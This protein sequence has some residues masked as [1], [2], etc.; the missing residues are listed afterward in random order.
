MRGRAGE[1]E[2]KTEREGERAREREGESQTH[3]DMFSPSSHNVSL[4]VDILATREQRDGSTQNAALF[5]N[6]HTLPSVTHSASSS[7]CPWLWLSVALITSPVSS[8]RQA[9]IQSERKV[10]LNMA[11]RWHTG[12]HR[13]HHQSNTDAIS[14]LYPSLLLFLTLFHSSFP[15]KSPLIYCPIHL[16]PQ[17]WGKERK[18]E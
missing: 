5:I 6:T 16:I 15:L 2:R 11:V 3:L 18:R 14:S 4:R 7:L 13:R 1:R 12:S 8:G 17:G 9:L 10:V